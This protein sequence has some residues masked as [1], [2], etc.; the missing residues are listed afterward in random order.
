M[1]ATQIGLVR[2]ASIVVRSWLSVQMAILLTAT[3]QFP[4]LVHAL[5]HLRLP[6]VLVA[7]VAFMYRYLH[8]LVDES[9]RLLRARQSRSARA[10][11]RV[12]RQ[13]LRWRNDERRVQSPVSSVQC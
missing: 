4:D 3:T 11:G 9:L 13:P 5:R 12:H 8:V 2:F 6:Q 10:P 7:I 1:V